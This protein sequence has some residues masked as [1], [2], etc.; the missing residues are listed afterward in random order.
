[1][2]GAMEAD[3]RNAAAIIAGH[4][5][6]IFFARRK[7][8]E[9]ALERWSAEALARALVRLHTAILQTRRRPD[10]SVALARQALLGIG[11]ESARLQRRAFN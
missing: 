3:G 11:V 6:P 2:R 5:P 4:R 9:K 10:L 1:M 7:L 8:M